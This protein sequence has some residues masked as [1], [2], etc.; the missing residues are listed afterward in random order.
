MGDDRMEICTRKLGEVCRIKRAIDERMRGLSKTVRD[1]FRAK[2]Y[3]AKQSPTGY[4]RE[5]VV[6]NATNANTGQCF[7][8]SRLLH[9]AHASGVCRPK[10]VH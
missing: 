8:R 2:L 7:K 4:Q 1:Q 9:Y 3:Q 10:A 6:E 5:M